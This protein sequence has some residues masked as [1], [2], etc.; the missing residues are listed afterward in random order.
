MVAELL[1]A[2]EIGRQGSGG[3][4]VHRHEARFLEFGLQNAQVRRLCLEPDVVHR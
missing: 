3:C 2:S 4:W 1:T